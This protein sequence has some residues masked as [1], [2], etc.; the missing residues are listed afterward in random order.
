MVPGFYEIAIHRLLDSRISHAHG[1]GEYESAYGA[2][3]T[4]MALPKGGS[5]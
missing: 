3:M 4:G 2:I 5:H 1:E